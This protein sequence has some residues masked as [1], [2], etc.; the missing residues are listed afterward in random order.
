MPTTEID[1]AV[2]RLAKYR[3]D[4]DKYAAADGLRDE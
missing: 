3:T 4:P 2:K 1:V